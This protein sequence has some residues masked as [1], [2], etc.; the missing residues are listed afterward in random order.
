[1][2]KITAVLLWLAFLLSCCVCTAEAGEAKPILFRGI[3]WGLSCVEVSEQLK[4][5]KDLRIGNDTYTVSYFTDGETDKAYKDKEYTLY[6]YIQKDEKE[7][8]GE[9]AGYALYMGII[10]FSRVLQADGSVGRGAENTVFYAARYELGS[11]VNPDIKKSVDQRREDLTAKLTSLYGEP[12][13][14]HANPVWHGAEGTLVALQYVPKNA[15]FYISYVSES[16]DAMFKLL[17][18]AENAREEAFSGNTDG[19]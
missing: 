4:L 14:G 15:S 5:E 17:L 12:D 13:A 8:I 10:Y 6:T 7:A 1:M 19:L 9:I 11:P 16:G 18:D 2:K 3:P